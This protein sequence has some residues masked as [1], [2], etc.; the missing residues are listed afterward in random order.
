MI[1]FFK[2]NIIWLTFFISSVVMLI[3]SLVAST[4]MI[5][6]A[7]II[8]DTS[9]ANMLA[10]SRAAALL[11]SAEELDEFVM[12]EDMQTSEYLNVKNRLIAFNDISGTEYTYYLRLDTNTNKMQF[13]IDNIPADFTALIEPQVEREASPDIALSGKANTV[14][15]GSYSEGWEG[16]LTAFAPVYYSDGRLSNTVAGVDMLDVSIRK[17]QTNMNLLSNL[18][19]FAM[20]LVLSSCLF[21]LL[22]YRRKVKQS[23]IANEAKSSFLSRMSHEIRTP[24]SAI[25]GLCNM[26]LESDDLPTIKEYLKRLD[27]SSQHLR[28]IIDNVLDISK[29]ESGKLVLDFIPV[30][31]NQEIEQIGHMIRPQTIVKKQLFLVDIDKTIPEVLQYDVPHI[32]QIVVN[33]LSNAIKFT[34]E[35]GTIKLSVSLLETKDNKC[36][37]LWCVED[38]G[39]GI[40]AE[41]QEKLFLPFEQADSS[42]TRKYGGTGLGLSIA[43][44][45]VEMMN[46]NIH[47]ESSY[48]NGSKFI[49]NIWLDKGSESSLANITEPPVPEKSINLQGKH[50]LLVEDVETNQIIV[51]D[52]LERYGCIVKI[53]NNGLEGYKEYTANSEK[54]VMIL[55]DVQMPIM[56]GY[57]ATKKIR[58]SG[59]ENARQIPII[60]MTA[61]VYREDID[62]A[63]AAGM[64]AHIGKPFDAKQI[65]QVFSQIPFE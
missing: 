60:A 12:P 65:D 1:T 54:Y 63:L 42:T 26:S 22:L 37:L 41:Q 50:I 27:T 58:T 43:K 30:N 32:R 15:L 51:Q 10:L 59:L 53:T 39:I 44:Q 19:T 36:N 29:I 2:Q 52:I 8:E 13:I 11:V 33:L 25:V 31:L 16:Y 47:L 35:N 7:E 40:S 57:E 46:G 18:L 34:P 21:S 17:A 28:G 61:N 5:S 14:E 9:K 20:V 3:I 45:L 49:F 64:N 48:G 38:T 4:M 6:Y 23:Q 24:L 62:E 56:D 55:M